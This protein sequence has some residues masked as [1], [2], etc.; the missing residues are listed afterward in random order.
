MDKHIGYYS[1]LKL[2]TLVLI[3]LLIFS[4]TENKEYYF[5]SV[6]IL[7]LTSLEHHI[8]SLVL[9]R[10]EQDKG[11]FYLNDQFHQYWYKYVTLHSFKLMLSQKGRL[12]YCRI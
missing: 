7:F 2:A 3:V 5:Y 1:L 10:R 6:V 11:E 9:D 4:D 12:L 8:Y